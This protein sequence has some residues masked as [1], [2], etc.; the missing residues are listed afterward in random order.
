[1]AAL[2]AHLAAL[3]LPLMLANHQALA[4]SGA[5][6]AWSHLHYL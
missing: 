6:K 4:Q 3:K 5:D 1:M 2:R